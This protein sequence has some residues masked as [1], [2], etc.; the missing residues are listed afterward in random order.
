MY[1]IVYSSY[2]LCKD[3]KVQSKIKEAYPLSSVHTMDSRSKVENEH[4]P[5]GKKVG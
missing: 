5:V 3:S 4:K 2:K 1:K